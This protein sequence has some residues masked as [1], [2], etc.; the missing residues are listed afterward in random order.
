M[1]VVHTEEKREILE[2]KSLENQGEQEQEKILDLDELKDL[3]EISLD[4][5]SYLVTIFDILNQI[6]DYTK[7]LDEE[8]PSIFDHYHHNQKNDSTQNKNPQGNE[9]NSISTN[10][11][12]DSNSSGSGFCCL[13]EKL[14]FDDYI[15]LCYKKM[16]F[17]PELLILTMM[18]LDK[19]LAKKFV[20]TE[21]NVHKTFF[22]CMMETQK[23]YED[24]NFKNKDYAKIA[25]ITVEELL[26]LELEFL[27][28]LDFNLH[29]KEYD[30]LVYKRK[31]KNLYD[32]IIIY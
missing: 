10:S 17:S 23:Y 9:R 24:I 12:S 28:Y 31:L 29:I 7:E 27:N 13:I 1:S 16:E 26:E 19:L 30:F 11:S 6:M 3:N 25:G 18:N 20:L 32:Q 14:G 2:Q 4:A 21:T 5:N 15:A 22:I 8:T